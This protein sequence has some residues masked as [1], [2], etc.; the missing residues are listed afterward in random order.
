MTDH[1]HIFDKLGFSLEE[2][3]KALELADLASKTKSDTRICICGH[4]FGTHRGISTAEREVM[5]ASGRAPQTSCTPG[6]MACPCKHAVAVLFAEDARLFMRKTSGHGPDHALGQGIVASAMKNKEIRW[7]IDPICE[8]C[9]TEGAHVI[10]VSLTRSGLVSD[11]PGED[12][13]L[14]CNDC[15]RKLTV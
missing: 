8:N 6:R 2:G 7:L 12:N 13:A 4:A 9:K 3:K 14:I 1:S 15:R 10:P 5:A 11:V